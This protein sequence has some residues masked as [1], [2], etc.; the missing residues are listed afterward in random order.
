MPEVKAFPLMYAF[1]EPIGEVMTVQFDTLYQ[2]IV[3]FIGRD[4]SLFHKGLQINEID[5]IVFSKE[6]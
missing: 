3:F 2:V 5:V 6:T 4:D 1:S